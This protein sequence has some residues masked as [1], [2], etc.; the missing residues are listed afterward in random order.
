VDLKDTFLTTFNVQEVHEEGP[1][2]FDAAETPYVLP[3]D[4]H[5]RLR[6]DCNCFGDRSKRRGLCLSDDE[7]FGASD[8]QI[9]NLP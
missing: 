8:A 2:G 3:L 7:H 5:N 4:A 9:S 6:S 1:S